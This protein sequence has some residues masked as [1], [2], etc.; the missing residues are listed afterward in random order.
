[1]DTKTL[2][3]ACAVTLSGGVLTAP[4]AR[5]AADL[6]SIVRA[7][8]DTEA[9]TYPV[10]ATESG[11]HAGDARLDDTAPASHRAVVQFLHATLAQLAHLDDAR[12][13]KLQRDD[14]DVLAAEIGGELLEEEHVQKWRHSPDTYVGLATSAAYTL[15]ARD[16]A[17]IAQ[18]MQATIAR[19]R[20]LPRLFASAKLNLVAMPPVFVDIGLENVA[21]AIEFLSRDVPAAFAGVAD[22]KA[23]AD[24]AASTQ[25][26]VA[27]AQDFQAWLRVQQKTA[28]GS[29]VLGTEN[30]R[31]LLAADMIDLTPDEVLAAGR[32]Q[33][34]RDQDEFAAVSRQVSP[35]HPNAALAVIEHS[36][37]DATH[38]VPAAQETLAGI[39]QFIVTHKIVDLPG[40]DL[41]KVAAAV[42]ARAY[43]C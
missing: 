41:P 3:L 4:A 29:F 26:A 8:I 11:L 21:G 15:I 42:P 27:A 6:D 12:L 38:L 2:L 14:R 32:A 37:P 23:H 16:F 36:H 34:K 18:R 1:M 40:S 22:K 13:T 7:Y 9:A 30:F 17:P 39:R 24:L 5:A 35:E 20:Q 10:N 33:L 43:R 25:Q 19:E 31:R 28:H